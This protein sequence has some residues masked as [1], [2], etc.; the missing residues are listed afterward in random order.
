MSGPQDDERVLI[1]TPTGRDA[2]LARAV[3]TEAGLSAC[4]CPDGDALLR[5]LAVGA[6]AALITREALSAPMVERLTETLAAQPPWSDLPLVILTTGGP[7]SSSSRRQLES[8]GSL[9]N[10]TL[11]ERPLRV[12]TLVSII[13]VALAARRRQ[14]ELREHLAERERLERALLAEYEK[15]HRIAETLAALAPEHR[16]P[17]MPSPACPWCRSTRPRATRPTSAATSLMPS[18]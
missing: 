1:L 6:G 7:A 4:I 2:E 10:A 5:E 3:L 16:P 14:Y 9:G 12:P 17:R 18:P 13:R 8:L 15:Q 11:L